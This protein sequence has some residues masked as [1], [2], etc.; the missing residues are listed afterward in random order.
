M[1]VK[2]YSLKVD[3]ATAQKNV[4]ELNSSFEAQ[5]ELIDELENEELR[6]W[7]KDN[8]G[9]IEKFEGGYLFKVE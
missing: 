9:R 6:D 5:T 4:E 7:Y 2:E 3:T 8:W 1:V